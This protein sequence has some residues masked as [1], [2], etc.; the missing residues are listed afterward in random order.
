MANLI[1][2]ALGTDTNKYVQVVNLL[3]NARTNAHIAHLQT[4]SFAAHKALNEFYDGVLDIADSFAEASQGT[5][6]ILTGYDLGK[7]WSGDPIPNIRAQYQ[8]LVNLKS[9][10]KEGHLMQLMD[11][12]TELYSTTLYKLTILK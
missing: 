10:F 2:K 9:Q 5:Q 7:L 12:A 1:T 4:R 11:D 6:G 8:E 3:F